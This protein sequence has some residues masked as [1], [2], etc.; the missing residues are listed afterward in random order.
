MIKYLY[1]KI[2]DTYYK[3]RRNACRKPELQLRKPSTN[4]LSVKYTRPDFMKHGIY[5]INIDNSVSSNTITNDESYSEMLEY[6]KEHEVKEIAE[7]SDAYRVMIEYDILDEDNKIIDH[8]ITLHDVIDSDAFT[9]V[10]IDDNNIIK[11]KFNKVLKSVDH[12][13]IKINTPMSIMHNNKTLFLKIRDIMVYQYPPYD[14]DQTNPDHVSLYARDMH[15]GSPLLNTMLSDMTKIYSSKD[16]GIDILSVDITS[17]TQ[18]MFVDMD[19][20]LDKFICVMD[21]TE[22]INILQRD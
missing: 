16:N 14:M 9:T 3:V 13:P 15:F 18:K 10:S 5:A 11:S 1:T 20:V 7:L 6:L 4:P 17:N 19:I 21:E 12:I 22:I 8:S 2:G